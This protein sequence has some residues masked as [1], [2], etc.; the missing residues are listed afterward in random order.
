MSFVKCDINEDLKDLKLQV[1]A[2]LQTLQYLDQIKENRADIDV[3]YDMIKQ[4][5]SN[6][7]RDLQEGLLF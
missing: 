3:L 4:M 2:I 1:Q 7:I 5:K 6:E